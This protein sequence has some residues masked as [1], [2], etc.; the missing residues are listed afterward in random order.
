[1]RDNVMFDNSVQLSLSDYSNQVGTG[2]VPPYHVPA[3]NTV[4]SGNVMYS[5]R[6]EQLCMRQYNVYSTSRV[7]FGTFTNNR[8][9]SPYE[10]MSIMVR[11]FRASE[12][13]RYTL[14]QW[15]AERGTDVGSTRSPLRLTAHDVAETFGGNLVPNGSFDQNVNGWA[16]WPTEGR[17]TRDNTYLDNGALK[18]RFTDNSSYHIFFLHPE[19][20]ANMQDG[21]WYRLRFS[22]QSNMS[23]SLRVEAK[24]QSQMSGPYAMYDRQVPFDAERRDMTIIFRSDRSEPVRCQ[25]INHY[26]E[27]TYWL[28]NVVLERVAVSP[29]DPYERHV[30]LVN[31]TG[32][33]KDFNLQ[34]CWSDVDGNALSGPITLPAYRSIVLQREPDGVCNTT[35]GFD[36]E[37]PFPSEG[38]T[39]HPNPVRA[40]TNAILQHPLTGAA[41]AELYDAAGR[42]AQRTALAP[43]ATGIPVGAHL[44]PGLYALVLTNGQETQ[45]LRLMVE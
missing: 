36:E 32:S 45:R 24:G 23:G 38:N 33:S 42:R 2:A 12:E 14:E 35:T 43:G 13:K 26:T 11:T 15:R 41:H 29:V 6:P 4:Y 9:F 18:V 28:D 44:R 19:S 34:G 16:G 21:Q 30:L 7:D 8:Y 37:V 40:G 3:Y 31:E 39:V 20:M 22:L 10:E 25:F 17:V 1:V 27:G 5:V